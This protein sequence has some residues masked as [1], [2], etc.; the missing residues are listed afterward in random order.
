VLSL[1]D[2]EALTFTL[3]SGSL[4]AHGEGWGRVVLEQN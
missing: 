4:P 1:R 2:E 3:V